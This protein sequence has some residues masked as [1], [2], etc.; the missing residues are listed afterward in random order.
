MKKFLVVSSFVLMAHLTKA[1]APAQIN[2]QGVA[3]NSLGSVIP[4]QN[5]HLR[6]TIRESSADGTVLFQ[7][8]RKLRTNRFGLFTV[9]M[10]SAGAMASSG[11]L[12]EIDWASGGTKFLQV[13][14]D[15]SGG[16]HFIN[17]GASQLLSVPYAIY[18]A[19]AK[20]TGNAGGDLGG[21]YP[22]PTLKNHAVTTDKLAN[23]AVAAEKISAAGAQAGQ[24]LYFD[25]TN[26]IWSR[27]VATPSGA[28]GGDLAGTFP[29]PGIAANAIT[30]HKLADAAVTNGKLADGAVGVSKLADGSVM[31]SKLADGAVTT[32]KL[33]DNAVSAAKIQ[34]GS[35]ATTKLADGAATTAKIANNAVSTSKIQDGAVTDAKIAGGISYSKITG[36]PTALP[37][38]G[39]A[40]GDLTGNYPSPV[41][42]DGAITNSKISNDA[43]SA[44]KLQNGSVTTTKLADN[45]VNTA[46]LQDGAVT[47]TKIAAG[48]IP[49]SLPPSGTA[50]GDLSGV[51]PNPGIALGAITTNKLADGSVTGS[52][53]ADGAVN[54]AK[55]A[56]GAVVSNKLADGAATTT[57]I[58]DGAISTEKIQDGSIT[59]AKLAPGLVP[60]G[61]TLSGTAGGDLSGT[62]PNPNIASGAVTNSKIANG[63]VITPKLA[64]GAVATGKIAD[65]AVTTIKIN[66]TGATA[67]Q[68]LSFD[69]TAVAW[70]TPAGGGGSVSGTAGG[71]LTGA[72]PNPTIQTGAITTT[73]IADGAITNTQVSATAAID[74]SKLKLANSIQASDL[75]DGSV[76]TGKLADGAVTDAKLASGIAYSKIVGAPTALPPTG[77]AGGDLTGTYPN[78]T[79]ANN[80]ITAGKI[81]DGAVATT[82]IST[83][84][85]VNGQVLTY[86]GTGVVWSLP[87]V[88]GNPT[89]NAGGDL[90]GTYPNPT[91]NQIR[92]VAVSSTTP[93]NGQVLK[94]DGA[95][96]IP[97][98]DNTGSFSLPYSASASASANLLSVTNT[99]TGA[100]VEGNNASASDNVSAAIGRISSASAG[101]FSAGVKGIN[102]GTGTNGIGVY[103]VHAGSGW[104]VYG[105]SVGGTGIFGRSTNGFGLMGSSVNN[106]GL[107]AESE[108]G[109]AA[110]IQID[111]SQNTNNALLINNAGQGSGISVGSVQANA[112]FA[113]STYATAIAASSDNAHGMESASNS[114]AHAGILAL[115]SGD[116]A[117]AWGVALGLGTGVKASSFTSGGTALEAELDGVSSGNLAKFKT[118]GSNVARIDHT[119]K[120]YFNGGTTNSGADVAEAFAVEGARSAYEPGDVLVISQSSDRTVEKS[121]TPYS[122]L[123]AGVYATKPGVLLTEEDAVE[124][125]LGG[126]VP[127]GVIGVIP[128]KV[129]LEGGPIKRGDLI[130]TSSLAGVAMKAD[131]DKVKVGQVIGKA[132]EDY[133]QQGIGKIKLLVSVK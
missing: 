65:G 128:T 59:A 98:A 111:N 51:Y 45:A 7:E 15:P 84:G 106:T 78:P 105:N 119:G 76:M 34:D 40:G 6:L 114:S 93:A 58:A 89:G 75:T 17:M 109:N 12:Q 69:G 70:T 68:V 129:C 57:K 18:A 113:T 48:V 23:G 49:T 133:H 50:A 56:D 110:V 86:N 1:Q 60:G 103:G 64:D 13:E 101:A 80:A 107:Y 71:D 97:S 29:N 79:I 31:T 20:P 26:V 54:T 108:N 33:A 121:A 53:L 16:S 96:W 47:S 130:V 112:I 87:A 92:G 99:G 81:A 30:T 132:L 2:Y 25:G 22:N 82:K 120:G 27:P 74:Y 28:A 3:R 83:A 19:S 88:G 10:G 126:L 41:V 44:T 124:N 100:A 14:I 37:P 61:T 125:N 42:K 67:G 131:P 63:A 123:V 115:N 122:T 52:K 91:V 90:G 38:S 62:Y 11:S 85:A 95:Q 118:N 5:I 94:F 73:K 66:A 35:I 72:Y 4:E 104:G 9:A 102:N 24:V 117:G 39:R 43:V 77:T 8:T 116:G 55:L 46:K 127:M 36:A 32:S 21:A